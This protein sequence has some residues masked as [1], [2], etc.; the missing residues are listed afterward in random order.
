M[1]DTEVDAFREFAG[2]AIP[3]LHRI[4]LAACG[5]RHDADDLVQTTLEKMCGA[6]SRIERRDEPPMA[7]A[8]TVLVRAFIDSGR[9]AWRRSERSF[10]ILPETAFA[11]RGY[12]QVDDTPGLYAAL[13]TLTA[14]QRLVVV[15][16]HVEGLPVAEVARVLGSSESNVKSASAEGLARLRRALASPAD[17]RTPT[18]PAARRVVTQGAQR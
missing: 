13:S 17:A 18:H 12:G 4:A 11:E 8:R 2:A 10:E 15:L 7:Y 3:Q 6:W 9:R 16:R 1:K 14:R 5:D